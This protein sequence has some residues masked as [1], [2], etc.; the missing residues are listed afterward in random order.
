MHPNRRGRRRL[1]VALIGAAVLLV[2]AVGPTSAADYHVD[3]PAGMA[4][5]FELA[6]DIDVVGPQ[7][8]HEFADK[9]GNVVWALSAGRGNELTFTNLASGATLSLRATGA[10]TRT[11]P[12]P[13]GSVTQVYTGMNVLI[14][15][16]TD[17]PAGPSTTL[18]KG[19]VAAD[20]DADANTTLL[21]TSGRAMDICAAL[22]G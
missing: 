22:G 16:P 13:D 1:A 2:G 8:S 18:Y 17:K 14:M 20:F 19:R 12:H 6:V 3:F 21:S 7:S 9:D 10:V 15:Y 5:D 11:Y 4:C